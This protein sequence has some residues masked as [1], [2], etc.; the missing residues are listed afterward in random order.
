MEKLIEKL[1]N[2]FNGL[3]PNDEKGFIKICFELAK[4]L[5]NNYCIQ[6]GDRRYRFAEV[7]FYYFDQNRFNRKWNEVTYERN[8]NAGELFYHLSGLDIC[9]EG[10]IEK[11][12]NKEKKGSGGGI[13]IRSIW[14]E[15][16]NEKYITVGPLTCV[17]KILNACNNGVMPKIVRQSTS[18]QHDFTPCETY[19]YLGKNDFK[20]IQEKKNIDKD[21]KLAYYD[22][23]ISSTEWNKARTSYYT[24][25][26]I[27]FDKTKK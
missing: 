10:N 27:K 16:N 18:E 17:N 14:R 1:K 11:T 22:P 7:E 2:P 26:L 4:E 23:Q 19:R 13:L 3:K 25:R 24:N 21:L 5:F 20:A 6:C 12:K 8:R 15:E 9:F